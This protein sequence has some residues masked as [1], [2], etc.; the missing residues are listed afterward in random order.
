M[1]V[2]LRCHVLCPLRGKKCAPFER[3]REQ[4]HTGRSLALGDRNNSTH[5]MTRMRFSATPQGASSFAK[6]VVKSAK[7]LSNKTRVIVQDVRHRLAPPS[8]PQQQQPLQL[9]RVGAA[10]LSHISDASS[11]DIASTETRETSETIA[12]VPDKNNSQSEAEAVRSKYGL[13]GMRLVSTL[14]ELSLRSKVQTQSELGMWFAERLTELGT[15]YIKIGQFMSSRQDVFGKDFC[16]A[17]ESLRDRVSPMSAEEARSVLAQYPS[18]DAEICD[19]D[20]SAPIASASIGQVH[21]GKLRTSGKDIVVKI[22]RPGIAKMIERDVALLD[23]IVRFR[24]NVEAWLPGIM[25]GSSSSKITMEQ[26]RQSLSDFKSYL[27]SELDFVNEAKVMSEFRQM[28]ISKL[29]ANS[30]KMQ[31]HRQQR[32]QRRGQGVIIPKVYKQLC[33]DDVLVM[34]YVPSHDIISIVGS[35]S[36]KGGAIDDGDGDDGGDG[37]LPPRV[38]KQLS[39]QIMEVFI[40]QLTQYGLVHGDPHPGNMGVDSRGRLV[41]YDFGSTIT[42][43]DDERYA[44]KALIWQLLFSDSE[45][46][47]ESLKALGAE[48]HDE[49][50]VKSL[51][52]LYRR[53]MRT[54][55]VGIIR[56]DYDPNVP[57]PLRLPDKIMR[58]SRVYGMLEGT[59]KR[60]YPGFN[61]LDL[62]TQTADSLVL[63]EE[64][65][66]RRAS[67]DFLKIF[68]GFFH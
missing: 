43:T 17:L 28:Y 3:S 20:W 2:N 29:A 8:A 41:L 18:I 57:L 55:D 10:D 5:R 13:P 15:T 32:Q 30:Q 22:R 36:S 62:L 37:V 46:V 49:K 38:A 45:G 7:A 44:M 61:Y 6:S 64:F 58:L 26:T 23:S 59:C 12:P 63:D 9:Q 16:A 48:I 34:E 68:N 11:A 24:V 54:V 4:G 21:R 39:N 14:V 1:N 66:A 40:V 56:D 65:L 52:T 35:S 51:I 19:V 25:P 67:E 31:K 33:T 50:G 47:I 60:I 53:Y 42:I 27:M